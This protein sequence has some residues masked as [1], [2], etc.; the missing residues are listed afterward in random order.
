MGQVYL[1]G[2]RVPKLGLLRVTMELNKSINQSSQGGLGKIGYTSSNGLPRNCC[3]VPNKCLIGH[4]LGGQNGG[5][6]LALM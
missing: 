6:I 3:E 5:S 4:V 1:N 2:S